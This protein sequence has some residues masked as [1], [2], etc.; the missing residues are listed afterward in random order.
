MSNREKAINI[1]RNL[2]D[3]KIIYV[4]AYLQGLADGVADEPNDE[5]IEAINEGNQLI[6][7]HSAHPYEGS[8]SDFFDSILS[9]EE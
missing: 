2:P 9:E 4:L 3:N 8:T 6:R 1:V 5:T 7:D